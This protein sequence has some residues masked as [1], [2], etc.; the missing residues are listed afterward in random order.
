MPKT[1]LI[2]ILIF[3]IFLQIRLQMAIVRFCDL[4]KRRET[5][6]GIFKL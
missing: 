4:Q 6:F 2:G 1:T 3:Q 5:I